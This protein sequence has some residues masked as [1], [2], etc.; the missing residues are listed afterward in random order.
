MDGWDSSVP[1]NV[2]HCHP[3]WKTPSCC[4]HRLNSAAEMWDL[5]GCPMKV[6]LM[7][8]IKKKE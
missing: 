4:G 5:K 2:H 3:S 1:L 8:G 7:S 6:K